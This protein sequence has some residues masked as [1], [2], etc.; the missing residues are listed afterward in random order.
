MKSLILVTLLACAP[1]IAAAPDP[2]PVPAQITISNVNLFDGEHQLGQRDVVIRGERI[3]AIL[4]PGTAPAG[5]SIDGR[6]KTL[7]PGLIDAHTHADG[8]RSTLTTSIRYGVT[9]V[10]DM[11]GGST[12]TRALQRVRDDPSDTQV[13]DFY[14]AGFPVTAP[15]GHG[16]QWWGTQWGPVPTLKSGDDADAFVAARAAE[17]SDFIK[18]VL[19]PGNATVRRNTLDLATT[20]A[21]VNAARKRGKRT[22]VHISRYDDAWAA[23]EAGA[24]GI[25]HIWFDGGCNRTVVAKAKAA[26]AFVIPTLSVYEKFAPLGRVGGTPI[27]ADARLTRGLSKEARERI[28]ERAKLPIHEFQPMMEAVRCLHHAGVPILAGP[29]APNDGT[30][31]GVGM[32]REL[33]LLTLAGLSNEDALR[34]GSANV[35]DAF[36]LSDRGRI[37][38]GLRADLLLVEGNP[39][40]DITATRSIVQVFKRG[41]VVR[42]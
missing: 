28:A 21:V 35:A 5:P 2:N 31:F 26:N 12:G 22:V 4:P 42:R 37:A 38:S 24:N 18:V 32:H 41:T 30:W 7:L 39:A 34:A 27:L 1:P 20:K 6:G 3:E 25:A 13:A 11:L 10:L 19:A 29:D 8:D 15:G 14:G 40:D 36:G 33:E 23:F 16:T 17:G 9:T